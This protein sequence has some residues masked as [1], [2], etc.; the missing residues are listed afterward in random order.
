M[1]INNF[2][3]KV[4][5]NS[6]SNSNS[7]AKQTLNVL[8]VNYDLT[9]DLRVDK[10]IYAFNGRHPLPNKESYKYKEEIDKFYNTQKSYNYVDQLVISPDGTMLYSVA[11][12]LS[13]CTNITCSLISVIDLVS[14]QTVT[15]AEVFTGVY[16]ETK[17]KFI[18]SCNN[19]NFIYK[20]YNLFFQVIGK[21]RLNDTMNYSLTY[22]PY[23]TSTPASVIL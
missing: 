8:A 7:L 22:T 5:S 14:K 13:T 9:P 15:L 12:Y 18:I 19:P 20:N 21:T 10:R 6:N 23:N 4:V 17:L 3:F 1:S 2:E 16:S 11:D